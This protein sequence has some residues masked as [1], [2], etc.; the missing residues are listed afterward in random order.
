MRFCVRSTDVLNIF[1]YRKRI[2]NLRVRMMS[3]NVEEKFRQKL[4]RYSTANN[5]KFSTQTV[6]R[7]ILT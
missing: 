3:E 4:L 6:E 5:G 2:L 1:W 7:I